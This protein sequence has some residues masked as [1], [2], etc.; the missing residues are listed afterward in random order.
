[1]NLAPFRVVAL[2]LLL[3][4]CGGG[5]KEPPSL[6]G[7]WLGEGDFSSSHGKMAVKAQLEIL[8]DESYRFLILEPAILMAA[9]MEQGTWTLTDSSL[10]LHPAEETAEEEK[11]GFSLFGSA[12]RNFQPKT[13]TVAPG[14]K[15]LSLRDG[16]M[17][18]TFH[19]NRKATDV[20]RRNGEI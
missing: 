20:L 7:A 16:P 2:C 1:M 9:G 18:L 4:G 11:E 6:H 10:D 12:P 19:R 3:C 5:E 14:M 15:E 8:A 17:Q 13:L